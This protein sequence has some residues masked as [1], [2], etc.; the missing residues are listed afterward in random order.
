MIYKV[1]VN[2][3]IVTCYVYKYE[4]INHNLKVYIQT[5]VMYLLI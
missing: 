2:S 4:L 5:H 1:D 3:N